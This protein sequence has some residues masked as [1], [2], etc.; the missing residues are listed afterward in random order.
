MAFISRRPIL[1]STFKITHVFKLFIFHTE[2]TLGQGIRILFH[3]RTAKQNYIIVTGG[4]CL[5]WNVMEMRLFP[6]SYY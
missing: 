3:Q 2:V 5:C 1:Y 4:I 6:L